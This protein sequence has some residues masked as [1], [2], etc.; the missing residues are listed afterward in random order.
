MTWAVLRESTE[1]T[2]R[3]TAMIMLILIAASFISFVMT[4]IGIGKQVTDLINSS[5]LTPTQTIWLIVGLYF[6]LGM[7][8][9]SLSMMIATVPIVTPVV[10]SMG[11]DAVWFGVLM[12]LLLETALITPP[13]GLNLFVVQ[14]VR[15]RGPIRDVMIGSAP[16][17]VALLIMIAALIMWPEVAL[18]LPQKIGQ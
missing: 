15:T 11:F 18:W 10:L 6:V 17:V 7:F 4:S 16:F 9:E 1:G 13:V 12:M 14:G 2:M 8:M 5:G 3:T